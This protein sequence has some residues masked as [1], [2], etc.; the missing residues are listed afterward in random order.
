MDVRYERSNRTRVIM[1]GNRCIVRI[2]STRGP[3]VGS[4][5]EDGELGLKCYINKWT[6]IL[7]ANLETA[8]GDKLPFAALCGYKS[9]W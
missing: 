7:S 4:R 1:K 8:G 9:K 6:N 2:M 3:Q 5:N